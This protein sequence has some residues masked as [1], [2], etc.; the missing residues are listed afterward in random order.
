M[1]PHVISHAD[2]LHFLSYFPETGVFFWR[3]KPARNIVIGSVA[4]YL[5][6]CRDGNKRRLIRI[7]GVNY[8]AYRLAWFYVTT[9]WP[10]RG[11]D[12]KNCVSHDDRFEN[13]R[14]ATA[15]QQQMNK[16]A[17]ST[18]KSGYKGVSRYTVHGKFIGWRAVIMF[19]GEYKHLGV[20]SDALAAQRAYSSA[21]RQLAGEFARP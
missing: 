15:S 19:A 7:R 16:R 17:P 12:H 13:L 21:A 1:R 20:F 14:E 3:N 11:V 8:Y 10:E 4:G 9:R 2:L 5:Q 6:T 18:N